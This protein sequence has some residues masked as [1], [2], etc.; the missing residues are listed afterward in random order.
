MEDRKKHGKDEMPL[1]FGF[2]SLGLWA[3]AAVSH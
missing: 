1:A 2:Y 3:G